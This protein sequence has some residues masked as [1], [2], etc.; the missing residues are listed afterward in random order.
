MGAHEACQARQDRDMR[1]EQIPAP[2]G[3]PECVADAVRLAVA[4]AHWGMVWTRS[5][6]LN[7]RLE[8]VRLRGE[9]E[10]LQ[11]EVALLKEELRI[12]DE[13]MARIPPRNRPHY[14]PPERLAIL[15]LKAARGWSAAM[16]ARRFLLTAPTVAEETAP[17]PSPM[18]ATS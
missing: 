2:S 10:R 6:C 8:R 13:R 11:A 3:W 16:T 17:A 18:T 4:L 7:S 5:W 9:V 14:P 1:T 12:K 15:L